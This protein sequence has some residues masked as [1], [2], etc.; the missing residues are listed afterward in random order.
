MKK[1]TIVLTVALVLCLIPAQSVFAD[2]VQYP[3]DFRQFEVRS[4][5]DGYTLEEAFWF[6]P[7]VFA[8]DVLQ[9]TQAYLS[10]EDPVSYFLAAGQYTDE[11]IE[12]DYII[13]QS[14]I[15]P[16]YLGVVGFADS[17]DVEAYAA[18]FG[19]EYDPDIPYDI[20]VLFDD[21]SYITD[22]YPR[23]IGRAG[24]YDTFRRAALHLALYAYKN[25]KTPGF[26]VLDDY[27]TQ[28]FAYYE[29]LFDEAVESEAA[30]NEQY[31]T[32]N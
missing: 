24:A 27:L 4:E 19:Y 13:F 17:A 16:E 12:E 26:D 15:E 14:F 29:M 11:Q 9:F 20:C 28:L 5:E 32:N 1:R 30:L 21:L 25:G 31:Q 18:E 3:S 23:G 8:T 7:T 2:E 22:L 6:Y 10:P